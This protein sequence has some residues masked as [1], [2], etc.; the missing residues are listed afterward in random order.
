MQV[1]NGSHENL[2]VFDSFGT[3]EA[4]LEGRILP[5]RGMPPPGVAGEKDQDMPQH[6]PVSERMFVLLCV[7]ERRDALSTCLSRAFHHMRVLT[8]FLD[9]FI[10]YGIVAS[11]SPRECESTSTA[12]LISSTCL[13]TFD[14]ITSF[15]QRSASPSPRECESTSTAKGMS[16]E[17]VLETLSQG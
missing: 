11:L 10:K 6:G 7:S 3:E 9:L 5:G 4:A 14:N 8:L 12:R 16:E 15:L 17:R 13:E 2:R 1:I